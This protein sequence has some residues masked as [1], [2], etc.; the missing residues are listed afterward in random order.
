MSG[1]FED[2]REF[3]DANSLSFLD[4]GNYEVVNMTHNG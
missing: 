4:S 3:V 2:V 1:S